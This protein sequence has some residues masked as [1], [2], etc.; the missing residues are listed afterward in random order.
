[1]LKEETGDH[2]TN[3]K[4]RTVVRKEETDLLTCAATHSSAS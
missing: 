4:P 3:P 1:M 2:H